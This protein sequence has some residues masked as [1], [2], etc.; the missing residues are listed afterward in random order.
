[1]KSPSPSVSDRLCS[2]PRT[3]LHFIPDEWLINIYWVFFVNPLIQATLA[4]SIITK[5]IWS[6]LPKNA[7][8]K[9]HTMIENC[10]PPL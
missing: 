7:E 4:F 3:A 8:A 9:G 6:S 10:R 2:L 1:M 5:A